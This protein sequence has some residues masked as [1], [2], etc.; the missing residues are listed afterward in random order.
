MSRIGNY[1]VIEH[2]GHG[3]MG[4]VEKA[5]SPNGDIVAVKILYSQFALESNYV[6]RFKREALLARK[7]SHPNVVKILD[8]G[9]DPETRR[10]FIVMEYIE[11]QS[12]GEVLQDVKMSADPGGLQLFSSGET[13]RILRQLAGVLQ[14]ADDLG[15]VHRDIKPQ[16]I[17]LDWSGNVKLLDFGFAKDVDALVSVLSVTGQPIGTPPSAKPSASWL[18]TWANRRR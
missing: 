10:P 5:R 17:L 8:V 11:G 2:I 6:K 9:E 1:T 4:S 15:L 13:I 18:L 7:L 16:N 12:L 14:A 3:A